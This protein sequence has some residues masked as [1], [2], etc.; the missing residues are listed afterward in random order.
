ML[1]R[2]AT[3][4]QCSV[5]RS[6]PERQQTSLPETFPR[7]GG[8]QT[9][10]VAP[11]VPHVSLLSD[12]IL[13]GN[14]VS[15]ATVLM[16]SPMG[17]RQ[18]EARELESR[19][20]ELSRRDTFYKEQ[21]G[22]LERKGDGSVM[23]VV[24]VEAQMGVR[25]NKS[26]PSAGVL[27]NVSRRMNAEMYKLSSQQFHEAASKMEGTIKPRRTEPVCSGLQAQIL[28]CYRD[29]L[30]EVL[31]CSDL[32]KAYQHCVSAAHKG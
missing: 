10:A 30:Q 5:Q 26:W 28:R 1:S 14:P 20:A 15:P 13:C 22:R 3:A 31:L 21:L 12:S 25:M 4:T 6:F 24:R 17:L 29:H 11:C 18:P 7:W 9:A 32:V 2:L 19:E 23:V 27:V 8:Q 16:A